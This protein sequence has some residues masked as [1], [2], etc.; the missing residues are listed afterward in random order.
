MCLTGLPAAQYGE[1]PVNP[2]GQ[3]SGQ[4]GGNPNLDPE[5]SD[6]YSAGVVLRPRFLPGFAATVDYFDITV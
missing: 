4:I 2:A 3:Y 5:T 1:V 6:T